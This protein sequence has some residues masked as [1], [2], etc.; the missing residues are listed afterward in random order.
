MRKV[1]GL[2]LVREA[3]AVG[4]PNLVVAA[5]DFEGDAAALARDPKASEILRKLG[6][7]LGS[8]L[9][10]ARGRFEIA[11]EDLQFQGNEARPDLVIAVFGPE[12]VQKADNPLGS[13]PDERLLYISAVPRFDAGAEEAYVIR[14][15]QEQLNSRGIDADRA[16]SAQYLNTVQSAWA[17]RDKVRT[18]LSKTLQERV[19]AA[20][21]RRKDA[22]TFVEQL[23]AIPLHLRDEQETSNKVTQKKN[24]HDDEQ[25][26]KHKDKSRLRNNDLLI[27]KRADLKKLPQM[28]EDLVREGL[29]RLDKSKTKPT[30]RLRLSLHDLQELGIK[31]EDGRLSGEVDSAKLTEHARSLLKRTTLQK[32]RGLDNPSPEAL[33]RRYLV[34]AAAGVAATRRVDGEQESAEKRSKK[35]QTKTENKAKTRSRKNAGTKTRARA[36]RGGR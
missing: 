31:Y 36:Q 19:D 32:E 12:D 23:S 4:V 20:E 5:F 35:N 18:K 15:R 33:E 30:L 29:K 1:S 16:E 10:D 8:V 11:S 7:R 9:T 22:A 21:K 3:P 24:K 28:Q 13:A 2:I 25:N 27:A 34:P 6:R 17:F 26:D 14:L